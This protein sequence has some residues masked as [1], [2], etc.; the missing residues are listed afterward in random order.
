MQEHENPE[1]LKRIL[2]YL[3]G[4]FD[5]FPY[6]STVDQKYFS[7]L[8]RDFPQLD[9]EEELKQYHS[10]TLDQTNKNK[11]NHH[12]RFRLWLKRAQKYQCGNRQ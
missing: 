6:C 1:Q 10:W 3:G 9:I 5:G 2:D 8:L 12:S 7:W 11:I 4:A